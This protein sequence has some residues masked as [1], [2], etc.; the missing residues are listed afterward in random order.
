MSM[1]VKRN[2]IVGTA[3]LLGV[4]VLAYL[5]LSEPTGSPAQLADSFGGSDVIAALRD[6]NEVVA[7][8]ISDEKSGPTSRRAAP[9]DYKIIDGPRTV[10]PCQISELKSALLDPESYLLGSTKACTFDP[11][12]R[13][14]LHHASDEIDILFCFSCDQLNVYRNCTLVGGKDF[15][16]GRAKFVAFA[17]RTFPNDPIIQAISENR[18]RGSY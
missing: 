14:S 18:K 1:R 7:Y 12:V 11:G 9:L 15:D 4:S 8:H 13:V 5:Y 2:A 3:A 10:D 6:A 16:P 17:K